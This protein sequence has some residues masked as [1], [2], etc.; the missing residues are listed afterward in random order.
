MYS[1]HNDSSYFGSL[2][3]IS[4]CVVTK[5]SAI[6]AAA[7]I[8]SC[9][10]ISDRFEPPAKPIPNIHAPLDVDAA[11]RR[12]CT[13]DSPCTLD[14]TPVPCADRPFGRIGEFPLETC[15]RAAPTHIHRRE[16]THPD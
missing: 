16:L 8:T 3:W 15:S 12:T 9:A 6:F 13:P 14:V 5:R 11:H 2:I 7:L 10:T 1:D 4:L